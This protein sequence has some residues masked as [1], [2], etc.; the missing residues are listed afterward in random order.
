MPSRRLRWLDTP[1]VL[2]N[3]GTV[4]YIASFPGR[5]QVVSEPDSGESGTCTVAYRK[6]LWATGFLSANQR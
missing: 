6:L 2:H 1:L 4:N 5:R 3:Y